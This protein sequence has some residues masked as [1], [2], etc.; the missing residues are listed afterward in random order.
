M[1]KNV[2]IRTLLVC[3]FVLTSC[4]SHKKI[5][6]EDEF[7]V[8]AKSSPEGAGSSGAEDLTLD[9][10]DVPPTNQSK[11][12]ESSPSADDDFER[13]GDKA[14]TDHQGCD[15]RCSLNDTQM[16]RQN[17]MNQKMGIR[18]E[19]KDRIIDLDKRA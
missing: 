13:V 8:D 12:V 4:T 1:K 10:L 2:L 6:P 17:R 18:D 11:T 15:R 19:T 14:R 7:A 5:E 9:G 3:V 16:R